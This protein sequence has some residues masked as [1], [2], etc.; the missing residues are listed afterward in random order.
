MKIVNHKFSTNILLRIDSFENLL[1]CYDEKY[2]E[3]SCAANWIDYCVKSANNTIGDYWEC[4][5]AHLPEGDPRLNVLDSRG[6]PMGSNLYLLY[7]EKDHSY[8]LRFVPTILMPVMCFYSFNQEEIKK[9]RD[10]KGNAFFSFEK[11]KQAMEYNCDCAFLIIKDVSRFYQELKIEIPKS[12]S[13]YEKKLSSECFYEGFTPKEACIADKVDYSKLDD[14]YFSFQENYTEE[15]FW[16]RRRYEWQSEVRF[17]VPH[18]HFKQRYLED[19]LYDYK[20]NK[21][22]VSLPNLHTYAE[23]YF[24]KEAKG[25]RFFGQ[26]YSI[27]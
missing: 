7:R 17:V 23:I 15:L 5:F 8:F 1:K 11:Y 2:L 16:K 21:L 14:E 3:F 19:G 20:E 25:I 27:I 6:R 4:I 9:K 12:V 24:E 13:K 10:D 22:K 18:I 26:N